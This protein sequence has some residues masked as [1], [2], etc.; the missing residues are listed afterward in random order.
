MK[1]VTLQ[2][3]K[4]KI[5]KILTTIVSTNGWLHLN[6]LLMVHRP[7]IY[8]MNKLNY[9]CINLPIN[10]HIHCVAKD[11]NVIEY[12]TRAKQISDF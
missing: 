2:T 12:I 5:Y 3:C 1:N 8:N 7:R 6:L 11:Y 4:N 9:T 10:T